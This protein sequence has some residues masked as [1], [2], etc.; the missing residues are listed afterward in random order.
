MPLFL[1]KIQWFGSALR[2]SS[3]WFL[4]HWTEKP[5]TVQL[6]D[7]K[8]VISVLNKVRYKDN[9]ME[10]IWNRFWTQLLLRAKTNDS[11]SKL[12]KMV[13]FYFSLNICFIALYAI[14]LQNCENRFFNSFWLQ[15]LQWDSS[16]SIYE[17]IPF[18]ISRIDVFEL[19]TAVFNRERLLLFIVLDLWIKDD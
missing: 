17:K 11:N 9:L 8:K 6:M 10:S 13:T 16:A 7:L 18:W 19:E 15:R 12:S 1:R 3:R 5:T 2:T 14:V 4:A